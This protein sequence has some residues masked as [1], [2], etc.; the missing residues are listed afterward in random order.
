MNYLQG[1]RLAF[2]DLK[3]RKGHGCITEEQ[4]NFALKTLYKDYKDYK[5]ISME[6][7]FNQYFKNII[8]NPQ[9]DHLSF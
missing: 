9:S 4:Y 7:E 8:I 2:N 1:I 3:T 6:S 5:K